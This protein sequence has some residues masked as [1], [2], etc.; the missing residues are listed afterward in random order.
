VTGL[1]RAYLVGRVGRAPELRTT[2]SGATVAILSIATAGYRKD[3][4]GTAVEVTDWH[5]VIAS[6]DEARR[7]A[8][9]AT[10]GASIAVE[11]VLRPSRWS[12]AAGVTHRE[13]GLVLERTI[14]IGK[15]V[16]AAIPAVGGAE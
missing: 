15:R 13:V 9:Y 5:R 11:C 7:L 1:N 10:K 2:S 16:V 4:D 12:D 8:G 6:G 14:W 3:G